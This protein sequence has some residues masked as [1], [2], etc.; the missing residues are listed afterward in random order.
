MKWFYPLLCPAKARKDEVNY[1][2][3][4]WA[5][6]IFLI[7]AIALRYFYLECFSSN[8]WMRNIQLSVITIFITVAW[9]GTFIKAI[10]VEAEIPF[11]RLIDW[12]AYFLVVEN[13]FRLPLRLLL[14]ANHQIFL[15]MISCGI[16]AVLFTRFLHQY[17]GES[18]AIRN[19]IGGLIFWITAALLALG[20]G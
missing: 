15:S 9:A 12:L 17:Y 6:A 8:S 11:V 4:R 18:A 1:N 20:M 13:I 19:V 10:I 14:G 16:A 2:N 3:F 7:L 5:G